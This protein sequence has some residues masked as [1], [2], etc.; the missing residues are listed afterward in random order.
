MTTVKKHYG[1]P[2]S[3]D[4]AVGQPPITRWFYPGFV[5]YFE[6]D[7]VIDSVIP[8]DPPPLFHRAQLMTGASAQNL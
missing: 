4:P 3:R 2:R 5:V 7:Q 6:Y 1:S 8:G